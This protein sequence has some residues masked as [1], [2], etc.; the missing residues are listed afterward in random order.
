[1]L[2]P[3]EDFPPGSI[4]WAE[5]I[6]NRFQLATNSLS[7]DTAHHLLRVIKQI[8]EGDPRP[9][10]IWPSE[11]PFGTP[12]HYCKAVT[13]HPWKALIELVKEMGGD[14]LQL[15]FRNME[16]ELAK[17]Q[18]KYRKQG[19]HASAHS[20][21]GTVRGSNNASHLLRRLAR[22]HQIILAQ[23][24]SGKFKS[25]RAAAVAAGI[26]KELTPFEQI[27]RL[28]KRHRSKLTI[29]ERSD[30]KDLL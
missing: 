12:D 27:G 3:A 5:R 6:S 24:Q 21:I 25:V 10:E 20:A 14:Q 28:I 30:L 7:R 16:T 23:Y 9:W 8:W 1:M 17:A 15:D 18:A 4:E 13:G 2:G 29:Q 26:V 19:A 22:D 11:Q